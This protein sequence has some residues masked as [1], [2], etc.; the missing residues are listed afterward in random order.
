MDTGK[1]IIAVRHLEDL[2]EAKRLFQET[3]GQAE[4]L[5]FSPQVLYSLKKDFPEYTRIYS[6]WDFIDNGKLEQI[7]SEIWF[8]ISALFDEKSRSFLDSLSWHLIV[9]IY[10]L[11]V[12]DFSIQGMLEKKHPAKVHVFSPHDPYPIIPQAYQRLDLDRTLEF[13]LIYHARKNEVDLSVMPTSMPP[14]PPPGIF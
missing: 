13:C 14:P 8:H 12:S 11:L 4:F 3:G 5:C 10:E 6:I 7:H 1:I 9:F 2:S